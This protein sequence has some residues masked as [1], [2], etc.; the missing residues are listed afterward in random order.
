M[1]AYIAG[2]YLLAGA[3]GNYLAAWFCVEKSGFYAV[4]RNKRR[5]GL[6][7]FANCLAKMQLF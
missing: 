1:P 6:A 3:A 5:A 7:G 4:F 2:A